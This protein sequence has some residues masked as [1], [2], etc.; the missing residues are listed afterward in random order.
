MKFVKLQN[1]QTIINLYLT[2]SKFLIPYHTRHIA[3]IYHYLSMGLSVIISCFYDSSLLYNQ[4]KAFNS[5]RGDGLV[6]VNGHRALKWSGVATR[7]IVSCVLL[8]PSFFFTKFELYRKYY[9]RKW[10]VAIDIGFVT[11]SKSHVFL[12]VSC[13]HRTSQFF[14]YGSWQHQALGTI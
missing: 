3:C 10:N 7:Q 9:R 6:F 4:I 2:A 13:N 11:F 1:V 12:L 8:I 14:V 5:V